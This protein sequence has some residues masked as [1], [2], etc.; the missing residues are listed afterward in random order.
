VTLRLSY[1][2]SADPSTDVGAVDRR[3]VIA[4]FLGAIALGPFGVRKVKRAVA[5]KHLISAS[6][7]QPG[8]DDDECA[9]ACRLCNDRFLEIY[10]LT[11]LIS[12]T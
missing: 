5:Q 1:V 6:T 8:R 3:R 12:R 4:S 7:A 11:R 2:S 9:K 10:G